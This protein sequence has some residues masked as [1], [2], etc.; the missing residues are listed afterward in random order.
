MSETA[1]LGCA[2]GTARQLSFDQPAQVI[3]QQDLEVARRLEWM[4]GGDQRPLGLVVKPPADELIEL[5]LL[6][7][8]LHQVL[9]VVQSDGRRRGLAVDEQVRLAVP[10]KTLDRLFELVLGAG[11][12]ARSVRAPELLGQLGPETGPENRDDDVRVRGLDDLR[13]ERRRGDEW[14]VLPEDGF[15]DDSTYVLALQP[16][17]DA[18]GDGALLEDVPRGG[19]EEAERFQRASLALRLPPR[20]TIAKSPVAVRA[21]P[22]D[23]PARRAVPRPR[24]TGLS[25]PQAFEVTIPQLGLPRAH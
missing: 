11:L 2:G 3:F 13:L 5:L 24:S 16:L 8:P 7:E 4:E 10:A 12:V 18:A 23:G 1:R 19:N 6:S 25:A 20:R 9:F 15:Q 21:G 22:A 17:D 14:L